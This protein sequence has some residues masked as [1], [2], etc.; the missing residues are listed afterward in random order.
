MPSMLLGL[1][2][3][4]VFRL[5][6]LTCMPCIIMGLLLGLILGFYFLDIIFILVFT[7]SL[8]IGFSRSKSEKAKHV[9]A[10]L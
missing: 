9:G 2:S 3:G 5:L 6:V 8:E 7:F 4:L 1:P 10:F